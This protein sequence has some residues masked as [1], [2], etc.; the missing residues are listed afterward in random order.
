MEK[1]GKEVS[2]MVKSARSGFDVWPCHSLTSCGILRNLFV[3]VF[4][5]V[6]WGKYHLPHRIIVRIK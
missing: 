5:S 1:E 6:K 2:I 4:S 3:V